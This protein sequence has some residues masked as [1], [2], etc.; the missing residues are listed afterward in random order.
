MRPWSAVWLPDG[1]TMLVTERGGRLRVVQDGKL[2]MDVVKGL[3]E[4][5]PLVQGGLLDLAL[6]PDFEKNR[7]IYLT[8]SAGRQQANRT[9]LAC[10]RINKDLFEL[11][12]VK[13]LF[14]VSQAKQG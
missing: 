4:V 14:Q 2:R 13:T 1:K 11:T 9:M 12:E 7:T 5:L 8:Y 6:H 3:P 10:G